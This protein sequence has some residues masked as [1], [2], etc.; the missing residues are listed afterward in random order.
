MASMQN[1]IEAKLTEG[2]EPTQLE[3]VNKSHLHQGH[4]GDDGSGESHFHIRISSP[5]FLNQSKVARERM[6]Y[7]AL[8][9]E[10]KQIHALSIDI[11][12]D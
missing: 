9:V 2:L 3:V 4:M 10:M 1:Q 5:V 8:S 12:S 11:L 6:I 7:K